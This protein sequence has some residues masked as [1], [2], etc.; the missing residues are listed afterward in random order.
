MPYRDQNY[1]GGGSLG[2]S[3]FADEIYRAY[4]FNAK[5]LIDNCFYLIYAV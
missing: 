3:Y 2:D 1:G 5:H 4:K